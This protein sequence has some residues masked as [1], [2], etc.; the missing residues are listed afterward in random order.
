MWAPHQKLDPKIKTLCSYI[1]ILA[2]LTE[3]SWR[4]LIITGSNI[5]HIIAIKSTC[6]SHIL[7]IFSPIYTNK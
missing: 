5:V 4:L 6:G 7:C 2:K 3:I 1:E